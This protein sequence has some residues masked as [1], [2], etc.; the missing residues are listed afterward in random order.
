MGAE[1]YDVTIYQGAVVTKDLDDLIDGEDYTVS[2]NTRDSELLDGAVMYFESATNQ[3]TFD[4]SNM[5]YLS[6]GDVATQVI[7]FRVS[8]DYGYVSSQAEF[9]IVGLNDAPITSNDTIS[10]DVNQSVTIDVLANDTDVDH[11]DLLTVVSASSSRGLTEIIADEVKFTANSD[12]HF[13]KN[14]DTDT[15]TISYTIR[16]SDGATADGSVV[17]TIRGV[18][19]INGHV[20]KPN[21]NLTGADL[22]GADLAG[23]DLTGANLTGANLVGADLTGANLSNAILTDADLRLANLSGANMT[24]VTIGESTTPLSPLQFVKKD[25]RNRSIQNVKIS[26]LE[27]S[28]IDSTTNFA[29]AD[30]TDVDFSNVIF[31]DS[32]GARANAI[33]NG[34]WT[35]A[36][37]TAIGWEP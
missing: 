1:T 30:L 21:A 35:D 24:N 14:G 7:T 9:K 15:E 13:L 23:E 10:V 32:P 4:T 8:N 12:F 22:T 17:V 28:I 16:D 31:K 19:I 33:A 2:I 18:T 25:L 3:L 26:S 36:E 6:E 34:Q 37:L 29:G 20:I 27:N 11:G 5:T